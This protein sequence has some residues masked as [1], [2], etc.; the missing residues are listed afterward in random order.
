MIKLSIPVINLFEGLV[1]NP[2]SFNFLRKSYWLFTFNPF[3]KPNV[4]A[5]NLRGIFLVSFGFFCLKDPEAAFL[6]F[7]NLSFKFSKSLFC[8][9]TSPLISISSGKS[10]NEIFFGISLIVF[11][12]PVMSSPS[13]PSPLD[14]PLIRVPFLYVNEAEIPSI[15]GSAL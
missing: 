11:K 13:L 3:W 7:A 5:I 2:H 6:G 1:L 12:L 14:K 9:K 8:I 15:L 10:V 4:Y